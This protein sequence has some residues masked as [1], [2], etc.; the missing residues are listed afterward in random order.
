LFLWEALVSF[1]KVHHVGMIIGSFD[2]ARRVYSDGFGLAVDE[3][4]SPLPQARPGTFDKVLTL[5]FPIGEMY[6]EVS[7]PLDPTSPAGRYLAER[8][9]VGGL[10]HL[11][12][13]STDFAR[14]V[15]ALRRHGLR[16]ADGWSGADSVFLDPS[17]TLGLLVEITP[18]DDYYPHPFYRGAGLTTGMAHI[19]IAAKS[20]D[21]IHHL[22]TGVFGL[23]RGGEGRSGTPIGARSGPVQAADDDVVSIEYDLGGTVLEVNI[24]NDTVSGTARF[25]A[26]RGPLGAAYHH[27]CPFAPDVHAFMERG[28]TA[29][30]QEIGSLPPKEAG[31][32]GVGWFHPRSALGTLIEVWNLPPRIR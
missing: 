30:L 26:Q 23:Q 19:G 22:L 25:L 9:G 28:R 11:A 7:R 4:H 21:D 17:T 14:D 1:T 16:I 20:A 12:F 29:G 6:L 5:E 3:Q 15:A 32:H 18:S 24:P 13:A 31:Q 27:I 2:E 8:G 10:H